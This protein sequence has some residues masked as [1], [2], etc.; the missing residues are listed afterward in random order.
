MSPSPRTRPRPPGPPWSQCSTWSAPAPDTATIMTK[1][2]SQVSAA[3]LVRPLFF[4]VFKASLPVLR[5][6]YF[7]ASDPNPLPRRIVSGCLG[8]GCTPGRNTLIMFIGQRTL[9]LQQPH[10]GHSVT[11]CLIGRS[12][13]RQRN[14][15]EAQSA[16]EKV[17][18][19]S[20]AQSLAE[21]HGNR[22]H[23][24]R[25]YRPTPVLKTG[26]A[27]RPNAAPRSTSR[28]VSAARRGA[29]GSQP[30]QPAVQAH[31]VSSNWSRPFSPAAAPQAPRLPHPEGQAFGVHVL[32]QGLA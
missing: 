4:R 15:V 7:R 24:G 8:R 29:T 17:L 32:Q 23:P 13:A 20:P 12:L 1:T 22:T 25:D 6:M 10:S 28:H 27:T 16:Q 19:E 5:S 9:C 2:R 3:P 26:P 21:R 18:T 11:V 31:S 14:V 30:S